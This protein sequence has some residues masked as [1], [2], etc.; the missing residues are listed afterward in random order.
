[1]NSRR[2]S[3]RFVEISKIVE[4]DEKTEDSFSF[5]IDDVTEDLKY[6]WFSRISIQLYV[7]FLIVSLFSSSYAA[8][9][10]AFAAFSSID[11]NF[12]SWLH[13]L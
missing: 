10:S 11:E 3:Q 12:F 8:I 4:K 13:E 7:A 6:K 1:M 5:F 9:S 2:G